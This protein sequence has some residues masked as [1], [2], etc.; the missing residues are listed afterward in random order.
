MPTRRYQ[1]AWETLK[2]QGKLQ[3]GIKNFESLTVAQM[4]RN[5][6]TLRRAVS[7]EKYLDW[8]YKQTNPHSE[9]T[10]TCD[11]QAGI[12]H[13]YLNPDITDLSRLF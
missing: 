6:S 5:F 3:I 2:H 8:Q 4:E 11:F 1:V 13:F 9:I 7:K 12:I 10:S